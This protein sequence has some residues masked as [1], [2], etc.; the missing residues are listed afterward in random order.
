MP[1]ENSL[2]QDS[3][4]ALPGEIKERVRSAQ[5]AALRAVNL[6]LLSLY[7]DIGRLIGERQQGQTWGRAVVQNLGKDLRAEFPGVG[8]STRVARPGSSSMESPA[9]SK[10]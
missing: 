2:A 6:K 3:Y 10:H 9:A 8:M 5:Y 7:W 4:R 1:N